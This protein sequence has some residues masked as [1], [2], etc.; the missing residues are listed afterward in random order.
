[1]SERAAVLG[2]PLFVLGRH[3]KSS[4]TQYFAPKQPH[5]SPTWDWSFEDPDRYRHSPFNWKSYSTLSLDAALAVRELL[6]EELGE[7]PV[8]W[9]DWS[10]TVHSEMMR[11]VRYGQLPRQAR[12]DFLDALHAVP[13]QGTFYW[14]WRTMR[15][16]WQAFWKRQRAECGRVAPSLSLP[17]GGV[18]FPGR[19][20]GHATG[21]DS[22]I[23]LPR[24]LESQ[25]A[26]ALLSFRGDC[27]AATN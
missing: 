8:A 10:R 5:L 21:F 9:N 22:I 25:S 20:R 23:S 6:R 13:G 15:L 17:E 16:R 27:R 11:L 24:W 1:L 7:V 2:L 19:V 18:E 14:R 26:G 3:S 12:Q 4:G